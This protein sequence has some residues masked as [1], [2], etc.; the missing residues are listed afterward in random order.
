MKIRKI[1][2]KMKKLL[3]WVNLGLESTIKSKSGSKRAENSKIQ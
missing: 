3:Y 2:P 1:Y